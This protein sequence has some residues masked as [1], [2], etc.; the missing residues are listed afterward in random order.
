MRKNIKKRYFWTDEENQFIKQYYSTKGCI[1]VASK[2]GKTRSSVYRRAA[3][4][5]L[6]VAVNVA[7]HAYSPQEIIFIK[8]YY[9]LNGSKYVAQKLGRSPSSIH[10]KAWLLRIER[11]SLLEWSTKEI[12][13]LKKWYKKKRPS[14]IARRLKRSTG[15]VLT[16][17]R[18]LG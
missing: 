2:L 4:L 18:M 6:K 3:K 15:A 12:E 1:Y 8:K 17:A 10:R 13:Y 14:V 5:G 9:P 11:N 7:P 16:R